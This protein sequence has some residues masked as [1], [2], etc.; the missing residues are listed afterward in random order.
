MLALKA[1]K[2]RYRATLNDT[3]G[4]HLIITYRKT[5]IINDMIREDTT[6]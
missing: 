6:A 5:A 1:N 4:H 2:A 3:K